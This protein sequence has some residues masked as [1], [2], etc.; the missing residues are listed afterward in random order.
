MPSYRSLLTSFIQVVAFLFAAFGGFLERIA[1]PEQT[2]ARYAVGIL[3]FLTLLILLVISALARTVPGAKFRR[4]WIITGA[5]AFLLAIPPSFFYPS[6][7]R[8]YT[9]A[10]PP[11]KPIKRIRG[12][13]SEFTELVKTYLRDNPGQSSEPESLARKFELSDIWTA[14]SLSSASTRLLVLYG[15]LVLSLSTAIFCLLEANAV[16]DQARPSR[17]KKAKGG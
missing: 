14:E 7:I 13:D 4:A 9:W 3:S 17:S 16:T 6:A 1:P 15:W 8:L 12:R 10:Y 2:G 5:S 11:E